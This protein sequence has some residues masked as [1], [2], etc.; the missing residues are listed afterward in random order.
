[1]KTLCAWCESEIS[2]NLPSPDDAV[3]SHG[4]CPDCVDNIFFQLGGELHKYLD[5]LG[6]PV[7]VVDA[8]GVV[9]TANKNAR[10]MLNKEPAEI[11]G[12]LGGIVFECAYARLPGGCG[13]T[14]HCSG[15]TIRR[16]VME[17]FE[18]GRPSLKHSVILN[19]NVDKGIREFRLL[20]STE[21]VGGH[22]L[23]RIDEAE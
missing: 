4:I 10:G 14:E 15:C 9:V 18:T 16:A 20:I 13:R 8:D 12:F 17:T 21:K 2:S 6:S 19:R 1:M 23:L 5:S 11:E 22:V 7:I 3:I